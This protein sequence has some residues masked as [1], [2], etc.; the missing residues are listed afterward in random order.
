MYILVYMNISQTLQP[1]GNSVGLRLP[2]EVLKAAKV[3]VHQRVDIAI[4]H[5]KIVLTPRHETPRLSLQQLVDGIDDANLHDEYD[6]GAAVGQE[7]W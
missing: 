3:S 2:K 7:I 6:T 5:G 4:E 1:W